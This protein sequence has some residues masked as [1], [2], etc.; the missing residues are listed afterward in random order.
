MNVIE[1]Q[2]LTKYYGKTLGIKE[3]SFGVEKGEIFGFVGPNGAGKS[4]TIKLLLNLIYPTA[5]KAEIMG[6]DVVTKSKQIKEF[7]AYVPTEVRFYE[8]FTVKELLHTTMAF[9]QVKETTELHRLCKF[10]E[11]QMNKKITQL[12]M[13]N[14]KKVSIVSALLANPQ[15]LIMDEPTNGLDPLMQKRLFEELKRRT[16]KGLTVLL[17]SHNLSE[18]EEYCSRVAFIKKGRILAV[19]NLQIERQPA[20]I[21]TAWGKKGFERLQALEKEILEEYAEKIVFFYSGSASV[22]AEALAQAQLDD[23]IVQ[24]RSLEDQFMAMYEGGE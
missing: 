16:A 10:F 12:S 17:S 21:V 6:H 9:Y 4:T 13:G 23:F 1:I 15:V 8:G 2:G 14:K 11:L 20:K 3:V 7:T 22:L 5:G 18:I 24:N 19:E